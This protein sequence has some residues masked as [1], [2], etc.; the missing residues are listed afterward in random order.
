MTRG[1][2]EADHAT[3]TGLHLTGAAAKRGGFSNF[4]HVDGNQEMTHM[5]LTTWSKLI[6]RNVGPMLTSS[7]LALALG[8]C[9]SKPTPQL[10]DARRAYDRAEDSSAAE[11]N[12]H[13]MA[14]ARA[15]LDRAED[16]HDNDPGSVREKRLAE[17]AEYRANVVTEQSPAVQDASKTRTAKVA[18]ED[19]A[20]HARLQREQEENV[21]LERAQIRAQEGRATHDAHE[22]KADERKAAAALQ[23]LGQVANVKEE[24]RGVVITISGSL[25]FPNGQQELSPIARQNLDQV[26][27]ALAQQPADTTFQVSGHTDNSGSDKQNQQLATQRAKA[28]GDYLANSGINPARINV[29]G[30]GESQPI[31]TNDTAEGRAS[32]RR[33]EIVVVRPTKVE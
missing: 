22:T 19:T 5:E 32:N 17:R 29:V 4:A 27:H 15:A 14:R 20:E 7:A 6:N 11:R 12:P 2:S 26:A 3:T 31:A 33:V 18:A 24:P 16:A 23:N 8:A 13:D 10:V 30:R 9:A 1:R 25:L 28:V 21:R